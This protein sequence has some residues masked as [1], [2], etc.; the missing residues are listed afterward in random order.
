MG[1]RFASLSDFGLSQSS[2]GAALRGDVAGALN[3]MRIWH[4][5]KTGY[6]VKSAKDYAKSVTPYETDYK[7]EN[8]DT[9]HMPRRMKVNGKI[10]FNYAKYI[11]GMIAA[12]YTMGLSFMSTDAYKL[13]GRKIFSGG[14]SQPLKAIREVNPM[15]AQEIGGNIRMGLLV[16]FFEAWIFGPG[17]VMGMSGFLNKM[18]FIKSPAVRGMSGAGSITLSAMY[19]AYSM[20][21]TIFTGEKGD[22]W[23]IVML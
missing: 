11:P 10:I 17:A 5:Q 7:K 8:L 9:R 13:L 23:D 15:A 18:P 21:N 14:K 16:G 1:F 22:D 12:P 6:E 3:K 20:L 19:L 2:V 4:S